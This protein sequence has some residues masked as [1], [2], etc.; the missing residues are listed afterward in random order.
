MGMPDK[1]VVS[2]T[3]MIDG[4]AK[5]GDIASARCLFD[6][7]PE[8]D[9][10]CWSAMITGYAQ[11]GQPKEAIKLFSEMISQNVKPDEYAMKGFCLCAADFSILALCAVDF[12]ILAV[13]FLI[14][15]SVSTL[16]I[17]SIS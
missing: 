14:F 13:D 7:S 12:S 15:A 9:I 11:N 3:M 10:V 6:E 16:G 1:D 8:K 4:Y 17:V 5:L 2:F